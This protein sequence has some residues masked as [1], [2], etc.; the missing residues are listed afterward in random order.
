MM[1]SIPRTLLLLAAI[2]VFQF[3]LVA[4]QKGN[5]PTTPGTEERG[6]QGS[7]VKLFEPSFKQVKITD[8]FW[9]T[10]IETNHKKSLKAVLSNIDE[11]GTVHN[12][13]IAIGR[14]R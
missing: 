2:F 12:L 14:D 4:C 5:S 7:A 6:V 1:K 10:R 9:S 8:R 13:A 3:L 11:S